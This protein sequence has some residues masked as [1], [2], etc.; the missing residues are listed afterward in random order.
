MTRLR[1]TRQDGLSM[2]EVLV[3]VTI[4]SI[5][6]L[7]T[8][9]LQIQ[10]KR[11]NLGS[12]ERSLAS[13]M[14]HDMFERM[15]ANP[16]MYEEYLTQLAA[17]QNVGQGSL[18][19]PG[20]DCSSLEPCTPQQ[21][22]QYDVWQWEQLL[23]GSTEVSGAANTGGLV[24]P[25]AC[26][27]GPAGGGDGVYSIAINWRGHSEFTD[28]GLPDPCNANSTGRYDGDE[29]TGTLRRLVVVDS[30]LSE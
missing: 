21:L 8:A 17:S 2:I 18:S 19:E 29:G 25:L 14:I 5:G 12:V 28:G 30:Y 4:L 26:M 13:M 9:A 7:G 15:R 27:T 3:T 20:Q 11:A 16:G 23:I 22:A 6:L 24:L 1:I 10:S